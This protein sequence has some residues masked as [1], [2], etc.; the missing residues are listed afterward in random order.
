LLADLDPYRLLAER[1]APPSPAEHHDLWGLYRDPDV[2]QDAIRGLTEPFHSA[3]ITHVIGLEARGFLL[4]LQVATALG[5]PFVPVRKAGAYLPGAKWQTDTQLDWEGKQSH[6]ELQKHTLPPKARVLLVDDWFTTGSQFRGAAELVSRAA[7]DIV[8]VAVLAEEMD[9]SVADRMPGLNALLHWDQGSEEFSASRYRS[10]MVTGRSSIT[11][12]PEADGELRSAF[13]STM[14]SRGAGLAR[15]LSG[16]FEAALFVSANRDYAETARFEIKSDVDDGLLESTQTRN[17]RLQIIE[18]FST[19]SLAQQAAAYLARLDSV[20]NGLHYCLQYGAESISEM[21][22]PEMRRYWKDLAYVTGID[23]AHA[24]HLASGSWGFTVFDRAIAVLRLHV[25]DE[26]LNVLLTAGVQDARSLVP[27][28]LAGCASGMTREAWTLRCLQSPMLLPCG[29]APIVAYEAASRPAALST[30]LTE[31][32]RKLDARY[33]DVKQ[34]LSGPAAAAANVYETLY[35]ARQQY[36]I[37]EYFGLYAALR[38]RVIRATIELL[39]RHELTSGQFEHHATFYNYTGAQ[40]DLVA[41]VG[42][43]GLI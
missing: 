2:L 39:D 17:E 3:G 34:K 28:L 16:S 30:H 42:K 21:A 22:L 26:A 31:L 27:T 43:S 40:Q 7:S 38:H 8:G 15:A 33:A 11:F 6:L 29:V 13:L 5:L 4:G 9:P 18:I 24:M 10:K 23:N 35:K 37:Y 12:D 32:A 20:L 41:L 19:G 14:S 36:D 1:I 25:D